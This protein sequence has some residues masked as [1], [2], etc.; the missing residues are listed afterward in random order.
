MISEKATLS[1]P[2][3]IIGAG[4]AGTA[5]ALFAIRRGIVPILVG[6]TGETLYA[7]GLFDLYGVRHGSDRELIDDP[8]QALKALKAEHPE[9]PLSR[10]S[11]HQIRSAM[12]QLTAFL[13]DAGHPY[14]GYPYKN[15]RLITSAGTVKRTYRVPAS[16]W[17][18][19]LAL[20][21]KAACLIVDICG[22]RGFSARQ[23][24]GTLQ[25]DWPE[26][27]AATIDLPQE[28]RLGPKYAEHIAR[29]LEVPAARRTLAAAIRPHVNKVN[30][31]GLPAILGI[32]DTTGIRRDLEAMLE[33]PV[34]EIPTM[35]PAIAGVRLKEAFD[36]HLPKQGVRTFF[37]Q[38]VLSARCRSD[39]RFALEV[40]KTDP[41]FR[42]V[43]DSLLLA[44]GRFLGKGLVAERKGIREPL[45]NLP[46]H[47]PS[48]RRGWHRETFLDP[49]GHA[50]NRAGIEVD[51]GFRPVDAKGRVIHENLY[52]AGSILAH[53]DWMRTKS[54]T[55]LAV[56]TAFGAVETLAGGS[57]GSR[58]GGA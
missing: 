42:V 45:L 41:E 19:V 24:V 32:H 48:D 46:V 40:G 4:M 2:L 20:E 5:A 36:E 21:Q 7:S 34:F 58:R 31:L 29:G 22:L 11:A 23:I 13:A 37:H 47:Q 49:R 26:L 14:K 53:Q 55:G 43:A 44:T 9:H 27:T 10:L 18:G 35:P 56:A 17:N 39:G 12:D 51:D 54:G 16:A 30:Y 38:R 1:C 3:M 52:A 25:T 6:L 57:A 8:W 50:I 28:S 33:L 15:V